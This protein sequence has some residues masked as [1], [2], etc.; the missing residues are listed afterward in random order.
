MSW[1]LSVHWRWLEEGLEKRAA[2]NLSFPISLASSQTGA[3]PA[4]LCV[5]GE[6]RLG[7]PRLVQPRR[8]S[9]GKHSAEREGRAALKA[10]H[11]ST[12]GPGEHPL[13]HSNS[14][15]KEFYACLPVPL[16]QASPNRGHWCPFCTLGTVGR[17]I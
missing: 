4:G 5:P 7:A 1:V 11:L 3:A 2:F 6:A 15:Q 13:I 16:Q 9:S 17:G 8:S 10:V 12:T 14:K